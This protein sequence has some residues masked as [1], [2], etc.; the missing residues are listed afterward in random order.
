MQ[1]FP[2]S[3]EKFLWHFIAKQKIKF[4]VLLIAHLAWSLDQT[5]LPY[6]FKVFIERISEYTGDRS[7]IWPYI[8]APIFAGAGLWLLIEIL[9]RIFDFQIASFRPKFQ[10]DIRSSV[11]SYLQQHSYKF[12]SD[13]FAGSIVNKVNDLITS[14]FDIVLKIMT[15]YFPAFV[16]I[17]IGTLI[18][19]SVHLDFALVIFAW[20]VIHFSICFAYAK[21]CNHLAKL[22]SESRSMLTGKLVDNLTNIIAIKSF[23]SE[24][25]ELLSFKDYQDDE[26]NKQQTSLKLIF[27]VRCSLAI[28][29]FLFCGVLLTWLEIDKWKTGDI[30]TAEFIY[31]FYTAWGLTIFAWIT[32]SEL[33]NLFRDIG[34]CNQA[35]SLLKDDL[36]PSPNLK[37]L[38]VTKGKIEFKTVD[39]FYNK[40]DKLFYDLNV[41]IEA[42]QK[43]GLVGFSGSGKTSFANLI[44][45]FYAPNSGTILIDD[46]DIS[47]AT[48]S[49]IR[50][51]I[52]LI[53]QDPNLFHRSLM[54]NIRYGN[55]NANDEEVYE[56]A[57]LAH[58]HDFIMSMKDGYQTKV[59]ERGIKLSGGQRQR[60]AIAR[61]ILKKA[62]ILVLDEATSALDSVTESLIQDSL[63]HLMQDRTTIIIAHRLSTLSAMDRILVFAKGKIIEDGTHEELLEK[64][65][66]YYQMWQMQSGGFLP[67]SN[68]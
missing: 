62:P 48:K 68:S 11:Y 30:S 16:A 32:G 28:I 14:S 7:L 6:I 42:K 46:Q 1:K 54:D 56:A 25:Q 13:N 20:L 12:F 65:G 52:S 19:A 9:F 23:A 4:F 8:Q 17:I 57:K 50:S 66:H 61:A 40:D 22:H 36:T 38:S 44:M 67:E 63:A 26:Q 24:Q 55:Q 29:C 59:G 18:F 60:I 47:K 27:W 45:S 15:L 21:K 5:V 34:T 41:N 37:E 2:S 33:P 39:F 3:L 53:P 49:S 58:C 64:Q 35:L 31:I 51:Q 10:A 43:V